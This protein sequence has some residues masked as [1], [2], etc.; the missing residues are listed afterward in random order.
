MEVESVNG[1]LAVLCR[2]F[3]EKYHI[4]EHNKT[5]YVSTKKNLEAYGLF[6]EK[7]TTS[8]GILSMRR[9]CK[10]LS[11]DSRVSVVFQD[12]GVPM[13]HYDRQ[14]SEKIYKHFF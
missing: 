3:C 8:F 1:I 14:K 9:I 7:V 6:Q 11:A 10:E 12:F 4:I 13:L 2:D 5:S